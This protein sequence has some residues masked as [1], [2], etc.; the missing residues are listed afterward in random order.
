MFYEIETKRPFDDVVSAIADAAAQK[1][2]RVLTVHDVQATLAEKGF[3][4]GPYKIIEV[5]NSKKAYAVLEADP[6]VGVFLPCPICV[7]TKDDKTVVSTMKPTLMSRFFPGV[8]LGTV[9]QDVE[10]TM[11]EIIEAAR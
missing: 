4:R 10:K 3:Q 2:F 1:M 7:W 9:P 8:D 6:R 5:C 11:V